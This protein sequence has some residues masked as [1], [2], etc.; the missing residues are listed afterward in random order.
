MIHSRHREILYVDD[1]EE[2]RYAMRRILEQVLATSSMEA[3]TGT[4]ALRPH[5]S[6]N[7]R[8]HP[9]RQ[10]PRHVRL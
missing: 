6:R 1:T 5:P 4:E 2:Q 7:P 9:R 8:R 10:A 3:G